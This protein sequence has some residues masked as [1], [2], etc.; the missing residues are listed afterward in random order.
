MLVIFRSVT[1]NNTHT[2]INNINSSMAFQ[3][4]V[5]QTIRSPG[6]SVL[7]TR[8]VASDSYSGFDGPTFGECVDHTYRIGI[9][10]S[11]GPANW[12]K[13]VR[14]PTLSFGYFDGCFT[15]AVV[16]LPDGWIDDSSTLSDFNFHAV[17]VIVGS[18]VC[19][20]NGGQLE[21]TSTLSR[22]SLDFL[23]WFTCAI[24]S[25]AQ[26]KSRIVFF[27]TLQ[28]TCVTVS[29]PVC[30]TNWLVLQRADTDVFSADPRYINQIVAANVIS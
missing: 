24:V 12:S 27:A 25:F 22:R 17:L 10:L 1:N 4:N 8:T 26:L 21:L 2:I 30:G 15:F 28:S 11:V 3:G 19:S 6:F 9:S 7:L 18:S 16:S 29:V 20:A 13:V 5:I 14:A 23:R